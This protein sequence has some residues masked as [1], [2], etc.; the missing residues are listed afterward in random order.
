MSV[1]DHRD[2]K[3]VRHSHCF[4]PTIELEGEAQVFF[5]LDLGEREGRTGIPE[6][7]CKISQSIKAG[8]MGY[9]CKHCGHEDLTPSPVMEKPCFYLKIPSHA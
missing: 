4:M 9:V 7:G 3:I 6:E 8:K 2:P 1:R 5:E